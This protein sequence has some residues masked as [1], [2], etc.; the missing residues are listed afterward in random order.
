MRGR[1]TL[2][3]LLAAAALM[4]GCFVDSTEPGHVVDLRLS[5]NAPGSSVVATGATFSPWDSEGVFQLEKW[6][7]YVRVAV[8]HRDG[9]ELEPL[10]DA[11][12]GGQASDAC[13]L[14][15]PGS[16]PSPTKGIGAGEGEY[17]EVDVELKLP[18]GDN[19][20]LRALAYLVETGKSRVLVYMEDTVKTSAG[21]TVK[22]MDLIAGS[23]LDLRV[24]MTLH[25]AGKVNATI[26]CGAS[27]ADNYV[28][29]RLALRDARAQ[30]MY[31]FQ[32]LTRST[33]SYTT[34]ITGVPVGRPHYTVI[35]LKHV[36]DGSLL[37]TVVVKKPSFAVTIPND[38]LAVNLD[39][40][41][42]F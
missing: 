28:P 7:K 18:A 32:A 13:A 14:C 9:Y 11:R 27:G 19:R 16:W 40:A 4:V 12:Q 17:G 10:Q 20:R 34:E 31:P 42:K 23:E 33:D 3:A 5:L 21:K 38:T 26:R 2:M 37:K 39:I 6:S 30:V 1:Q 8:E 15:Y 24:S 29:Y 35:Q 36:T 25:P 22:T 41:C